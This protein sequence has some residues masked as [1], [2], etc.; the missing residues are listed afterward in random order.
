MSLLIM[1]SLAMEWWRRWARPV[2]WG[3]EGSWPS[4][5]RVIILKLVLL[6]EKQR[7]YYYLY[8]VI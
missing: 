7:A 5:D 6:L 8:L 3:V 2:R 4:L 1:V